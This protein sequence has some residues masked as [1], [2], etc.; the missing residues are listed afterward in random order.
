MK[1]E[2]A[3]VLQLIKTCI[4]YLEAIAKLSRNIESALK[5]TKFE[6]VESSIQSRGEVI[7]QFIASETQ[8][9]TLSKSND[10]A[11]AAE[12]T[13]YNERRTA[14]L[15]IIQNVDQHI[16]KTLANSQESVLSEIKALYRGRQMN[17]GYINPS[18]IPPIFF[19]IKE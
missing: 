10:S 1:Q 4:E 7:K 17:T 18:S 12:L 2:I 15:Q 9:G 6:Q 8:L 13:A 16:N 11:L 14:L 5:E 19:D 3:P